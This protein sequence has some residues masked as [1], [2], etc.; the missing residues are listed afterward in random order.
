MLGNANKNSDVF[1][2]V[3]SKLKIFKLFQKCMGF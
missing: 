3:L 2:V 1:A